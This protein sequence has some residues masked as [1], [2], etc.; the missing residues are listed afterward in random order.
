MK[1]PIGTILKDFLGLFVLT[2]FENRLIEELS[3][4]LKPEHKSILMFQLSHFTT[5][6]RLIR[7]L[8][9]PN[10]HGYTNFYTTKFGKNI[11]DQIQVKKFPVSKAETLL[12]TGVV[13]GNFGQIDLQFWLVN[14]VLF[15]IEYR[16]SQN[17]YYPTDEDYRIQLKPELE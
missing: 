4:V 1:I 12:A 15:T 8:P 9:E 5:V 14:G 3:L 13:I 16:S 7:Y 17:I 6:R 2:P 10:A 11:S